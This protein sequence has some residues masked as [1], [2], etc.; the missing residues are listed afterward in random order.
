MHKVRAVCTAFW[1]GLL[2][3]ELVD[4]VGINNNRDD[5]K[6]GMIKKCAYY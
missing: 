4:R 6:I 1:I 5:K 3:A 2:G